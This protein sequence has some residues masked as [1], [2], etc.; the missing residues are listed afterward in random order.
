MGAEDRDYCSSSN[1]SYGQLKTIHDI[2]G[3]LE[4]MVS[5]TG[6]VYTEYGGFE[7]EV[8]DTARFPYGD[9]ITTLIKHGFEIWI[10]LRN[11]RPIIRA[12]IKGD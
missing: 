8:V 1:L 3:V 9:V 7:I 5:G 11:D 12:C 4:L 6:V 2:K 10:T